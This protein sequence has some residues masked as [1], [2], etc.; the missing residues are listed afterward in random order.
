MQVKP[1]TE[2][3]QVPTITS[4]QVLLH[5]CHQVSTKHRLTTNNLLIAF[6]TF[7]VITYNKFRDYNNNNYN[8]NITRIIIIIG[9]IAALINLLL[10]LLP[11]RSTSNN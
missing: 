6:L 5:Y 1:A 9:I 7:P 3:Q 11:I 4:W 10:L 2:I 8:L